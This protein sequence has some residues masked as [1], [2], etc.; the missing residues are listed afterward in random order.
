MGEREER[1]SVCKGRK[2]L[3]PDMGFYCMI[4]YCIVLYNIGIIQVYQVY[5]C[6]IQILVRSLKAPF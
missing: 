6:I 4:L 2:W 1:I 5:N 3:S